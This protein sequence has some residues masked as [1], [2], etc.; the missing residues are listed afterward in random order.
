LLAKV[1]LFYKVTSFE[2]KIL[3]ILWI[4]KTEFS[5]LEMFSVKVGKVF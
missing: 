3:E 2:P 5:F 4:L 1:K